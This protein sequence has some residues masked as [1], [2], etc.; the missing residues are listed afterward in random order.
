MRY[1]K[2]KHPAEIQLEGV[3]VEMETV[4]DSLQSVTITDVKGN[5]LKLAMISYTLYAQIPAPPKMVKRYAVQGTVLTLPVDLQFAHR[6][7][8]EN[9]AD[10]FRRGTSPDNVA[11]TVSEVLVA[12]DDVRT[13]ALE[14]TTD[15]PF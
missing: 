2:V 13:D 14:Y 8:A 4:D 6:H 5:V 1:A 9:A 3:T 12:E 10:H 15:L 11:L 7:E